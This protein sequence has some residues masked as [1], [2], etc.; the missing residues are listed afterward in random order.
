M[1]LN[2]KAE[3]PSTVCTLS[4]WQVGN[5]ASFV[6]V[7]AWLYLR[8][9]SHAVRVMQDLEPG[10]AGFPGNEF[11]NA[12]G[13]L[14]YDLTD[15]SAKLASSD[16]KIL[17]EAKLVQNARVSARDGL[18]FQH[19]SWIAAQIQFPGAK[20]RSP[21]VRKAD[22][23]FDGLLIEVGQGAATL[24]RLVLCED[25][26]TGNPRNLVTQKVWPEIKSIVAGEKDLEVLDAVTAL[27]ET[28]VSETVKEEILISAVWKRLREYRIAVTASHAQLQAGSYAHIFGGYDSQVV[29]DVAIRMADVM[30]LTDVRLY[31]QDLAEKVIAK[32][33]DL[34]ANV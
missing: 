10:P 33:Q 5:A 31:L 20:L 8:K 9:P 6:D 28:M 24:S 4:T 23:G 14:R 19:I 2:V 13:L 15:I 18:L 16:P 22:K 27:L 25:K 26:A 30:P 34:A 29:G 1:P 11:Q 17:A 3:P 12:I 32:I 21:H 7:L